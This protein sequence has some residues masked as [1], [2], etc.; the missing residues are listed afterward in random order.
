MIEVICRYVIGNMSQ[1]VFYTKTANKN[2]S[3]VCREINRNG[4][5]DGSY[6]VFLA[7]KKY[8]NRQKEKRKKASFTEEMKILIEQ[9]LKDKFSP[10]DDSGTT[11]TNE[12]KL[13]NV[14]EI[15]NNRN[16]ITIVLKSRI[17]GENSAVVQPLSSENITNDL[18]GN[19]YTNLSLP[20]VYNGNA[21][22]NGIPPATYDG[23]SLVISD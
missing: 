9:Q 13:F 5:P 21:D 1:S 20:E 12:L 4:E 3:V 14:D 15:K 7:H 18:D 11:D 2:K 17:A 19:P 10:E 16:G 8:L 23:G 6:C 22:A